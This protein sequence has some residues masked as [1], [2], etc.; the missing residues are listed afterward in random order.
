M[1][2]GARKT[3]VALIPFQPHAQPQPARLRQNRQPVRVL[4][5]R[6]E[7]GKA[8]RKPSICPSRKAR[9]RPARPLV[10]DGQHQVGIVGHVAIA[11]DTALHVLGLLQ[12]GQRGQFA[13]GHV[14]HARG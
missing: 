9:R 14:A 10:L 2:D 8:N 1:P 7:L 3:P 4:D 5:A 12:L 6:R 11:P 13:E